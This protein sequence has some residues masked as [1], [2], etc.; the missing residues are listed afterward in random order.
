MGW[1]GLSGSSL[2]EQRIAAW[3]KERKKQMKEAEDQYE[4]YA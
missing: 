4:K 1:G 2:E 3:E